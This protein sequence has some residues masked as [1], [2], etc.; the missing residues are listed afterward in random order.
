MN[1]RKVRNE[2]NLKFKLK[3]KSI[4]KSMNK[5]RKNESRKHISESKKKLEKTPENR[6]RKHQWKD[7]T[8]NY[9]KSIGERFEQRKPGKRENQITWCMT[10]KTTISVTIRIR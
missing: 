6:R 4:H 10:Q 2:K 8:K 3:L 9:N 7:E 1:N 5:K